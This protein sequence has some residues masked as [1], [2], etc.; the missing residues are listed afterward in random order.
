MVMTT[1]PLNVSDLRTPAVS[2]HHVLPSLPQRLTSTLQ[3]ALP[4]QSGDFSSSSAIAT[5][6]SNMQREN[7]DLLEQSQRLLVQLVSQQHDSSTS[8]GMDYYSAAITPAPVPHT[9]TQ[10][11]SE[12]A[13]LQ[14]SLAEQTSQHLLLQH[15]VRRGEEEV[16]F[17]RQQLTKKSSSVAKQQD[18]LHQQLVQSRGMLDDMTRTL[19]HQEQELSEVRARLANA[20]DSVLH[21]TSMVTCLQ[22]ELA[23]S[24]I[25]H[26]AELER[27]SAELHDLKHSQILEHETVSKKIDEVVKHVRDKEEELETVVASIA[28]HEAAMQA[29]DTL[30]ASLEEKLQTSRSELET[31]TTEIV[32]QRQKFSG[33]QRDAENGERQVFQLT[34]NLQQCQKQLELH[35]QDTK[36][37]ESLRALHQRDVSDAKTKMSQLEIAVQ[38]KSI[39]CSNL[40]SAKMEL[41]AE[42]AKQK[43]A[44]SFAEQ[45]Y[46]DAETRIAKMK[47]EVSQHAAEL[48][49]CQGQLS[50]ERLQRE[51]LIGS[52]KRLEH[53]KQQLAAN[54]NQR[55]D[56]DQQKL[57][58]ALK[59][60]SQLEAAH[61]KQKEQL[62]RMKQQ[63]EKQWQSEVELTEKL[64][65][66]NADLLLCRKELQEK[67]EE[68]AHVELHLE[69]AKSQVHTNE[70]QCTDLKNIVARQKQ[71]MMQRASQV[72]QLVLNVQNSQSK[73]QDE[74]DSLHSEIQ[75]L[76]AQLQTSQRECK[77]F[78]QGL[79]SANSAL[80]TAREKLSSENAEK[81]KEKGTTQSLQSSLA[82]S[83]QQM[84]QL[85]AQR[86]RLRVEL[87]KQQA[88]HEEKKCQLEQAELKRQS[89]EKKCS[90]ME[91]KLRDI[92]HR[93]TTTSTANKAL[94]QEL[95][96]TSTMANSITKD[97]QEE[98]SV[99]RVQHLESQLKRIQGEYD[100]QVGELQTKHSD[101]LLTLE[102][103][104]TKYRLEIT[105]LAN[106]IDTLRKQEAE[107]QLTAAQ[108]SAE[109]VRVKK[110]LHRHQ[111]EAQLNDS[112]M[113]EVDLKLSHLE[114]SVAKSTTQ[115]NT[116]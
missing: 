96:K 13:D 89:A 11:R 15:R 88:E 16:Q 47:S 34:A 32:G 39:E 40:R 85:E 1:S 65:Q 99:S 31:Q 101:M 67:Q 29:K 116:T 70:V 4:R 95:H 59:E 52:C 18:N 21:K 75:Q 82:D 2:H 33:L 83:K 46:Q 5:Q 22:K 56:M 9:A 107:A 93:L 112:T 115:T 43:H 8:P 37:A 103:Q 6:L 36:A 48:Q 105:T 35:I 114:R 30:I 27:C 79:E 49:L 84:Q 77:T 97:G 7:D 86:D 25:R 68:L 110:Q 26:Q 100:R 41:E 38:E 109:L 72:N 76:Q 108:C 78:A 62:A 92:H 87:C 80:Q 50:Q 106:V 51:E 90:E 91:E 74:V 73:Q 111:Q 98:V 53:D 63:H 55:A 94:T 17:L 57:S 104:D 42:V 61:E 58:R 66:S 102:Q 23:D 69:E 28:T 14:H 24:D 113:K 3:D 12:H 19:Q 64:T 71:S 45:R 44:N 60:R 10:S 20:E 54:M 81:E